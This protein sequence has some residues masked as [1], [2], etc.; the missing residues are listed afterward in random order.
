LSPGVYSWHFDRSKKLRN[1]NVGL[2]VEFAVSPD[3]AVMVG[4]L[5][6]SNGAR[7]RY[8]GY[9]WRPLHSHFG[10]LGLAAGVVAGAFDGYPNYKGGGWFV[11][12]LPLISLEGRRLGINLSVIPTLKNR[13]DGAFSIQIKL[14]IR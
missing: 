5:I 1:K 12:P 4:S 14:R 3:H 10:N 9:A 7:T 8:A 11:A 2:G 13:V 6:N